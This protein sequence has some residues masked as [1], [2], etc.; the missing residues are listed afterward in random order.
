MSTWNIDW[1]IA[2]A[3]TKQTVLNRLGGGAITNKYVATIHT[4]FQ[5]ETATAFAN[6]EVN[7]LWSVQNADKT[8]AAANS[9]TELA[10]RIAPTLDTTDFTIFEV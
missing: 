3:N 7:S 8:Y 6:T 9:Q 4:C 2:E 10:Q 1:E 5:S